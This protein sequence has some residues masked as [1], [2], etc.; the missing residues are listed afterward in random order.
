VCRG[1]RW[2]AGWPARCAVARCCNGPANR[3]GVLTRLRGGVGSG[4]GPLA[5]AGLD[6]PLGLAVGAWRVGFGA[7][8]V[9]P[10]HPAGLAPAVAAIGRA[11][12]GI[13]RST[14]T[15]WPAN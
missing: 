13:T 15:P 12:V 11:V 4:V 5:Q 9:P 6:E 3:E 14:R 10:E 2:V 8:V 7:D 1:G